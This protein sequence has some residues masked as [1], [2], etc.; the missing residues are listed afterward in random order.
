MIFFFPFSP[1]LRCNFSKV[2]KIVVQLSKVFGFPYITVWKFTFKVCFDL[3]VSLE[4]CGM[5][6]L[7]FVC[8]PE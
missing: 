7:Q 4:L 6:I 1:S 2:L 8:Y 3:A 5:N